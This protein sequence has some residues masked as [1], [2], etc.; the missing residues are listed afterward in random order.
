MDQTE[1][2]ENQNDKKHIPVSVAADNVNERI[3]CHAT[4]ERDRTKT[5]AYSSPSPLH[6]S[7]SR[8][9]SGIEGNRR[10]S[11]NDVFLQQTEKPNRNKSLADGH[12]DA[13]G[14]E[15]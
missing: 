15:G 4:E 13:D 14:G 8:G 5:K 3:S 1:N 12:S 11:I 2:T 10:S 9:F 6:P 7:V